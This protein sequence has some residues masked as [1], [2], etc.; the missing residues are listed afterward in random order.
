MTVTTAFSG[1]GR[2]YDRFRP[3]VW[4]LFLALVALGFEFR[5]PGSIFRE[6]RSSDDRI[7]QRLD[8]HVATSV[9]IHADLAAQNQQTAELVTALARGACLDRPRR[10]TR[11][12]G[13]P[14]EE[15]LSGRDGR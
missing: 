3:L 4:L 2:L 1:L 6:L 10:E 12:M 5:T 15:L 8:D 7:E 11:L 9:K 13:L 14:C